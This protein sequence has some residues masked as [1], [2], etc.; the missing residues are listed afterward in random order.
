MGLKDRIL[1]AKAKRQR[2]PAG[3]EACAALEVEPGTL[4]LA[5]LSARERGIHKESRFVT[6]F[7][8]KGRATSRMNL[9]NIEARL[10]VLTLVDADGTR[11]FQDGD[12]DALGE[13]PEPILTPLYEQAA[14]LNGLAADKEDDPDALK[15]GLPASAT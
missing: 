4:F 15:N 5:Q 3:A 10:L 11:V 12:A 9:N 14:R 2:E 8:A 6:T 13:L 1:A 7:D